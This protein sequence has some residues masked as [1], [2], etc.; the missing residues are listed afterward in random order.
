M[1]YVANKVTQKLF[2][3]QEER[4]RSEHNLVNIQKTHERMQ[5]ENKSEWGLL[6][7]TQLPN[8]TDTSCS[9]LSALAEFLDISCM[10]GTCFTSELQPQ[11]H[12]P[13]ENR[14]LPFAFQGLKSS[15]A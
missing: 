11:V 3:H 15:P 4:L 1:S 7:H 9:V 13:L 14:M 6:E 2:P 10:H 12:I 5:T 8:A